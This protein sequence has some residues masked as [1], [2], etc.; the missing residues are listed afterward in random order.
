[1]IARFTWLGNRDKGLGVGCG[2]SLQERL[3]VIL[4]AVSSELMSKFLEGVI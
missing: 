1:M 2:N 4:R 3:G